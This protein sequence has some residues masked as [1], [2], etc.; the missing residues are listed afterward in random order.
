MFRMIMRS[1]KAAI[2]YDSHLQLQ[3]KLKKKQKKTRKLK[4]HEYTLKQS[5]FFNFSIRYLHIVVE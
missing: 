5:F 3:Q 2:L 4:V 1:D